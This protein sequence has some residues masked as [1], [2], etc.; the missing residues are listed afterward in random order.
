AAPG[1]TLNLALAGV[2]SYVITPNNILPGTGTVTSSNRQTLNYGFFE[3]GPIVDDVPPQIV[4]QTYD[5]VPGSV[6]TVK[7][8]EDVSQALNV[9]N[10]TLVNTTTNEQISTGLMAVSYDTDTNSA[11]F[12][13]PGYPGGFLP[14]GDYTATISGTLPD[15]FGNQLGPTTSFEF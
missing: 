15:R 6:Y 1:D 5:E 11:S 9:A 12:T 7:F 8:S 3:T 2:Q 13:L 4:S 10:L 14:A